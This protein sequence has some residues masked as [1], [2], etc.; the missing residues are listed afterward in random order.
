MT[1]TLSRFQDGGSFQL[2]PL[3]TTCILR[4]L[5]IILT[6]QIRRYKQIAL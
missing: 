5:R 3:V 2:D 6:N 1:C 4:I